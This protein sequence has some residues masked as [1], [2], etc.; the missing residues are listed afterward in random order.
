MF[1]IDVKFVSVGVIL[2][3]ISIFYDKFVAKLEAKGHQDGF[4]P[5]LV[6]VGV[7]YTLTLSAL[8]VGWTPA[9]LIGILFIF[10]G[11]PMIAGS[12]NRYWIG[13]EREEERLSDLADRLGQGKDSE[14]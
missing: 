8:I 7:F 14:K 1:E 11:A 13:K 5:I 10:S 12:I 6:V 9:I 3:I 4:V 2:L